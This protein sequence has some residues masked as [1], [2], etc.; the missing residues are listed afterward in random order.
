[1]TPD[2]QTTEVLMKLLEGSGRV[3]AKLE[4]IE[5]KITQQQ[6][7]T[8]K[9]ENRVA[10]LEKKESKRAGVIVVLVFLITLGVPLV[11]E[12]LLK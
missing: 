3:E 4:N 8:A 7:D 6:Y 12:F 9:L 2:T 5:S 1:M 10:D 11:K